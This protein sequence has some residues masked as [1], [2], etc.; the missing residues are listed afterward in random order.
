[1][2]LEKIYQISTP[3]YTQKY[4][5]VDPIS[6]YEKQKLRNVGKDMK[7]RET[8]VQCPEDGGDIN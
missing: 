5:V 1:M 6:K 3:Y 4:T 8:C 7:E 2:H